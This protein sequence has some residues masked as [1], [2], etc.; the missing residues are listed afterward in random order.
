MESYI[1]LDKNMATSDS[2]DEVELTWYDVHEAP[3]SLHG[4][5]EPKKGEMFRRLPAEV[6]EATSLRVERFSRE[7]AGGRVRFS[8]NSP[9]VA[10]RVKY[11]AV[12]RSPHLTLISSAGFDMYVEGEYGSYLIKEFRMPYKME[13]SYEKVLKTGSTQMRSYT[14]DFPVHAAIENLEIGLAPEARV[15][16]ARPY[17]DVKPVVFYGSSIV[18]GTAAS[19]PG[20]TYPAMIS[21]ELNVDYINLGFSGSAKGEPVLA[22]YMATLPMSIFVCD[23]DFNA[24]DAQELEQTHYPLYE[25]IREKNPDVP[26][27]MITRPHGLMHKKKGFN[28]A[29]ACRDVIMR[30]YLKA[31]EAGDKN[32]Y[33]IDGMSFFATAAHQTDCQVDGLHP[34]DAGFMRMAD[35]IGFVIRQILEQKFWKDAEEE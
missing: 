28:T 20:T 11:R 18:H 6:G 33:F 27:I 35:V 13:D 32:V 2:A 30:S 22:R 1:E 3:F 29:L 7:S 24:H 25:V 12:G 8:T 31:R 14:V 17:R 10:I 34:N 5:F 21:R 9:Y 19:R 26:Y 15:A 4:F 16:E 23:Y